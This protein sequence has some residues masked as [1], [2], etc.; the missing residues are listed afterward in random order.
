MSL[1]ETVRRLALCAIAAAAFAS[2]ASARAADPPADFSGV[3]VS[4]DLGYGFGASGDWCNCTFLPAVTDMVGGEG[5]IIVGGGV[6]YDVRLGSLVLEMAARG[7][8]ADIKFS[9][10]C[11]T[12]V[13]SGEVAWLGETHVGA[14][15]IIFD[16]ILIA[17]TYGHA[18]GDVHAQAGLAPPS[19]SRHDGSTVT[20]RVEQGWSGGW[21]MG[22]EYRRYELE[23]D[24]EAPAAEV[25]V[26]WSS[27]VIALVIHYELPE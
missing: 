7:S 10:A 24:N 14:G 19:T 27:Q 4:L 26:D 1:G 21:R 20:A 17:G 12:T 5:G 11:G 25:A 16:D 2:A 6:G 13:C 8:H 15:L 22:L 9:E 3:F 23:G 18:F